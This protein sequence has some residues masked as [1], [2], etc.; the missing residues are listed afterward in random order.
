MFVAFNRRQIQMNYEWKFLNVDKSLS[1]YQVSKNSVQ[2]GGICKMSHD[3]NLKNLWRFLV[4]N[5][6]DFW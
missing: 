4:T 3:R 5:F 2:V 6:H 1:I